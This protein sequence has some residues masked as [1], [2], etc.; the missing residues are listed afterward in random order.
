LVEAHKNAAERARV[1]REPM[2]ELA[3]A[4]PVISAS[5]AVP[6]SP[7]S[8]RLR[9]PSPSP[10]F[11]PTIPAA[12]P[13]VAPVV[14]RP[15]VRAVRQSQPTPAVLADVED[16]TAGDSPYRYLALAR[17]EGFLVG[18]KLER[19]TPDRPETVWLLNEP[20]SGL[21][22]TLVTTDEGVRDASLHCNLRTDDEALLRATPPEY[23]D[24]ESRTIYVREACI[25]SFRA[26]CRRLRATGKLEPDW[27]VAPSFHPQTAAAASKS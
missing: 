13:A 19:G 18:A 22:L 7:P 27:K 9:S 21:R 1:P 3:A 12:R 17:R 14:E 4:R 23:R 6:V 11:R 20:A 25:V 26:R 16:T 2:P 5:P 10:V 15:P 24:L 8:A